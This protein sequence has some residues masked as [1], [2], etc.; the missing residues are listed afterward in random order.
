MR[1][2]SRYCMNI[3]AIVPY[4]GDPIVTFYLDGMFFVER[5]GSFVLG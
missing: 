4:M 3:S 2:S 1:V 5:Q